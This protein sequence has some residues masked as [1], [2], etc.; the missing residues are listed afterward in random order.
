MRAAACAHESS[1]PAASPPPLPG[2]AMPD[3]LAT[4]QEL[5]EGL[6]AAV[7][8]TDILG[9]SCQD[10]AEVIGVP[11]GTVKSRLERG[12]GRIRQR[13]AGRSA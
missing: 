6:R 9:Y 2:I 11:V 8:L 12:R 7:Y 3:L 1:L 5:P 10:A 13:L 4:V